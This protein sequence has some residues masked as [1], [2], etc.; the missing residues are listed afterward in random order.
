MD[1]SFPPSANDDAMFAMSEPFVL[2]FVF[3]LGVPAL[4][5][6]LFCT[7]KLDPKLPKEGNAPVCIGCCCWGC[8]DDC[9]PGDP[10][11][12]ALFCPPIPIASSMS[13]GGFGT[14]GA[15]VTT[16]PNGLREPVWC[17]FTG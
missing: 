17:V 6:P 3:E 8:C 13:V 12:P 16:W 15:G 2:V 11:P 7:G 9:C 4:E 1:E 5:A 14:G 10:A